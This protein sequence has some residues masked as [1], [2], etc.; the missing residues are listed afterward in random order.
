MKKINLKIY[1]LS[2][3][4]FFSWVLFYNYIVRWTH[5]YFTTLFIWIVLTI[6]LLNT[7]SILF[8]KTL[9]TNDEYLKYIFSFINILTFSILSFIFIS[10]FI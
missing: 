1:A 9:K 2:C 10:K 8:Y 4:F 5:N 7:S 6:L 3:L